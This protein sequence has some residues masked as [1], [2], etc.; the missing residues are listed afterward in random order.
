M[1]TDKRTNAGT[2]SRAHPFV[3]AHYSQIFLC[4]NLILHAWVDLSRV[5]LALE[6]VG[7]QN[8]PLLIVPRILEFSTA[9][10]MILNLVLEYGML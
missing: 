3:R 6:S 5:D 10:I 2:A 7:R 1:G 9:A 8:V 4:E